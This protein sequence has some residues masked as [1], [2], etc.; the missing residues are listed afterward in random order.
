MKLIKKASAG[1][2][3]ALGTLCLVAATYAPF[4]HKISHQERVSEAM[5]CLLFGLPITGAGGWVAWSPL[6][7]LLETQS[8][9]KRL[10]ALKHEK[11]L[12]LCLG[13]HGFRRVFGDRSTP[14]WYR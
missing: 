1:L 7:C 14:L 9:L 11:T 12:E 10:T 5:A 4:N 6:M 3:L 13:G 2:L 8:T